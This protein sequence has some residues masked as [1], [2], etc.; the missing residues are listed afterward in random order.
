M[1]EFECESPMTVEK[2]KETNFERLSTIEKN[3]SQSAKEA[4][5]NDLN[6]S[7]CLI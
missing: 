6:K 4:N 2:L 5:T 1:I 3:E 7:G